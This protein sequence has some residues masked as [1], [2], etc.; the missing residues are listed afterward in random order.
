MALVKKS[1]NIGGVACDVWI[2]EVERD[3]FMY[4]GHGIAEF[5]GY[6]LP[7]K[8]VRDHV[9]PVWRKNWIEIKGDLNWTPLV[10]SLEQTQLPTNWQL[11][12][13]SH[14]RHRRKHCGGHVERVGAGYGSAQT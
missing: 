2:V 4:A 6:K 13:V 9:K 14:Q 10:T 3:E 8:A 12:T 5:L 7:A 11:N 1:C